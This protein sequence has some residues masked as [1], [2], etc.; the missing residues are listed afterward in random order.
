MCSWQRHNAAASQSHTIACVDEASALVLDQFLRLPVCC[1]RAY[2]PQQM[3]RQLLTVE[4][5][6]VVSLPCV[7]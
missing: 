2:L 3:G 1:S 4:V 7:S 5:D 6:R